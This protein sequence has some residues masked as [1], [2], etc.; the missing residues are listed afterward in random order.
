M[1]NWST[2]LTNSLTK[3]AAEVRVHPNGIF[4][5]MNALGSNIFMCTL[6]DK[7]I[8]PADVQAHTLSMRHREKVVHQHQQQRSEQWKEQT[9]AAELRSL[10]RAQE[11]RSQ[12]PH[13]AH[14]ELLKPQEQMRAPEL[15][16]LLE[17]SRLSERA[18]LQ[19]QEERVRAQAL[20]VASGN[21]RAVIYCGPRGGEPPGVELSLLGKLQLIGPEVRP[22]PM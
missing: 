8:A 22:C 13:P 9:R 19:A 15:R 12:A 10:L 5:T 7:E 3:D 14:S 20:E 2:Q 11:L 17:Q 16:A 18:L 1:K 6:C 4:P 21:D